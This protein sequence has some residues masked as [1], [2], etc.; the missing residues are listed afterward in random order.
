M[1]AV[2][3]RWRG[4]HERHLWPHFFHLGL[5]PLAQG[6]LTSKSSPDCKMRFIPASAGNT[7]IIASYVINRAVY[8]RWRG[9]HLAIPL[10]D[11]AA[12]GLSPLA[13]GTPFSSCQVKPGARFIPAGAGNT[14]SSRSVNPLVAVYPR[15]RGEHRILHKKRNTYPG[16][17]PLAR[18]TL[19]FIF[20]AEKRKRFI[21]AGAGNTLSAVC[22][23]TA[24]AVYPRWRGE[25]I[26]T[27]LRN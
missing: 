13:R 15:W 3:P 18:G 27:R 22:R 14:E 7:T 8:P 24:C 25:H 11:G 26:T 20:T 6:T 21:P 10:V 16:L 2:Y 12:L 19:H 1:D 5:S 23:R 17:S 9:E 4:E